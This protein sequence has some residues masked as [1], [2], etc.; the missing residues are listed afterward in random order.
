MPSSCPRTAGSRPEELPMPKP[1]PV[2]AA[3]PFETGPA[4]LRSEIAGAMVPPK[5]VKT[6]LWFSDLATR[7]RSEQLDIRDGIGHEAHRGSILMNG[8]R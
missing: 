4:R 3:I 5:E 8:H 6:C 2:L 1:T 7:L